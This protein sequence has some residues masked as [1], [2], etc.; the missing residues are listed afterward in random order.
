MVPSPLIVCPEPQRTPIFATPGA[1]CARTRPNL[2]AASSFMLFDEFEPQGDQPP[3][4]GT[5]PEGVGQC[6]TRSKVLLGHVDGH[7]RLRWAR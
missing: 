3:H 2:R 4:Q 6:D 5:V 7:R 1:L